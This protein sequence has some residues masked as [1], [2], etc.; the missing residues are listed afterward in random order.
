MILCERNFKLLDEIAKSLSSRDIE[1]IFVD[2]E[3]MKELNLKHRNI[4]KITDVLSFPLENVPNAILGSIVINEDEAQRMA[5]KL[6]HSLEDEYA[7]L[8]IHA[9]LHLLGFDHE[10][11][12][13]QMRQKEAE[14]ISKFKLPTSLIVRSGG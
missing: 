10:T 6:N 8:F 14:L 4:D 2:D 12:G 9:L 7:L 5:T 3:Q 13:G 1:L 11:D